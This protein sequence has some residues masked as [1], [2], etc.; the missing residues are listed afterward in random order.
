[1]VAVTIDRVLE[2]VLDEMYDEE[3]DRKRQAARESRR[4]AFAFP[5]SLPLRMPSMSIAQPSER[6]DHEGDDDF[7]M[8]HYVSSP[9]F[10]ATGKRSRSPSSPPFPLLARHE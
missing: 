7:D 6:V 4:V 2:S 9:S 8:G 1:M 5:A 10:D 3:G